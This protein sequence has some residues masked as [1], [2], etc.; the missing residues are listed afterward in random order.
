MQDETAVAGQPRHCIGDTIDSL[1]TRCEQ[2]GPRE[3]EEV[4][5]SSEKGKTKETAF[6]GQ[7]TCFLCC[8]ASFCAACLAS[9]AFSFS[10]AAAKSVA[11][12]SFLRCGTA[13]KITF[14]F[15]SCFFCYTVVGTRE[16]LFTFV[17]CLQIECCTW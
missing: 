13:Q 1:L 6:R 9:R 15:F 12:L 10:A 17:F 11:S 3:R 5:C 16:Y 2:T 7:S 8:S 4:Q 14:L